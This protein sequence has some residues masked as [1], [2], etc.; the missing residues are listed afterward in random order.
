MLLP[1]RY[2]AVSYFMAFK[3]IKI[4]DVKNLEIVNSLEGH[5]KNVTRQFFILLP[6]KR[7]AADD[8]GNIIFW[9]Y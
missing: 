7:A 6:D 9:S 2:L 8:F 4:L 3:A 1:D 5:E